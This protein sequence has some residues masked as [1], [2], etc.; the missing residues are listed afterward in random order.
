MIDLFSAPTEEELQQIIA[1]TAIAK[2]FTP[3]II[4]GMPENEYH[5]I[6]AI[7]SSPIK[8]FHECPSCAF[9]SIDPSDDMK[10][11]SAQDSYTLYGPEH[12]EQN[13]IV[14]PDF[15]DLRKPENRREKNCF[16]LDNQ[17]SRKTLLPSTVTTDNIPTLKAIRDVDNMLLKEH[18]MAR[19][20]FRSGEQQASM[21]WRDLDTG[22]ECKGRIDHLPDPR[23]RT[24][25]DLKKCAR[26]DNFHN[27]MTA[28]GYGLQGGHYTVGARQ[29]EI[30]AIGFAFIAFCFG[31]PP[32]VRIVAMDD[33]YMEKAM[34]L[35]CT[36]VSL[37]HE[38][39]QAGEFP[40][41][42][43]PLSTVSMAGML[44]IKSDIARQLT[45]QDLIEV[46]QPPYSWREV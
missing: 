46:M 34:R 43:I 29:N 7:G 5:P 2:P 14:M 16:I 19:I 38:C 4:H 26:L 8:R 15:G 40:D 10:L 18:P 45:P 41:Y 21:F 12:F 23:Y 39:R 31:A 37:I 6:R 44:N 11:G 30:D 36:T 25:F 24:I 35:A 20:I 28:L 27:Q 9:D 17:Y 22:L 3:G 13:F 1:P 42:S 33:D 32:K